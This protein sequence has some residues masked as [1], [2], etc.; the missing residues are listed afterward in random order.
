MA[1]Y[2]SIFIG[3][4]DLR[5]MADQSETMQQLAETIIQQ[6]TLPQEGEA[7]LKALS[8][9]GLVKSAVH[10]NVSAFA[11]LEQLLGEDGTGAPEGQ[12]SLPAAMVAE[13]FLKV[14]RDILAGGHDEYLLYGGRGSTKSSFV[15]M[16]LLELLMTRPATHA[17]VCRKVKETLRD[18][19]YAQIQWAI[20]A[21]GLSGVFSCKVSPLEIVYKPTGQ[22]IFFRGADDPGKLKSIKPPFG[23][24]GILWF[25]ELDQYGGE[26]EIRSIEQ[27]VLRGADRSVVFKTFNPPQTSLSWVNQYAKRP[28]P[29]RMDHHSTYLEVPP[30][31]LGKKFL[32]DAAFLKEANP[33]AYE[34]EY[35]GVANGTGGQVFDHVTLREIPDG[36]LAG[37]D[38]IYRG[39]DW[40]WYPDPFRYVALHYQAN[41]RRIFLFAEISGNKLPNEQI[42]ELLRSHGVGG[43]DRITADSGG[44]GP[45]SIADLKNSG[46][47]LRAARKGPGSVEYSMKWLS[48][49]T[50]IVIDPVRCPKAAEEFLHYE[51]ERDREGAVMSGY[52]DRD[53]HSI[54]AV[55]YALETVWRR[56]GQ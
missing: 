3:G 20:G 23:S 21:L 28:K 12:F 40:G 54:D 6:G 30:E 38:R 36:E 29:S 10:G 53:N 5:G 43:G 18:S 55:R 24:I 27:S 42:G 45:K 35:L 17:V 7:S 11:K 4:E 2:H 47:Y 51:Y 44:E 49:L 15:S 48:S 52:P 1:V 26:E 9:A 13:P 34:H 8:V 31:W 32:E 33:R 22:K 46:F 25:E 37:F 19:V 56:R 41:E 14:Y 50:E 39:I 16:V